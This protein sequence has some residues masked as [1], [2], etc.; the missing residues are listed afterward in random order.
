VDDATKLAHKSNVP[1]STIA[2]GTAGGT[3]SQG[4]V[5]TGGLS[6]KQTFP[7][8]V[9]TTTLQ[10]IAQATGG[11]FSAAPTVAALDQVFKD[12]GSHA[13]HTRSN[14]EV[15]AVAIGLALLFIIPGILLSGL[16]FRRIA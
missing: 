3:V 9:D 10:S 2:L 5:L 6:Q 7:V 16:W 14:H 4:Q 15:T 12:L 13:A 1:I 11:K 8:P